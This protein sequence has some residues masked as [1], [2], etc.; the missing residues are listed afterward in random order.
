MTTAILLEDDIALA[1]ELVLGVLEPAEAATAQAR[2]ATDAAFAA[3]VAR[4][5][6]SL[7]P[8]LAGKDVVPPDTVWTKVSSAISSAPVQ[9][10]SK[11]RVRFWQGLSALSTAA[12]LVLAYQVAF[13]P[14]PPAMDIDSSKLIAALGSDTGRAS[15]TASY[16]PIT[17]KL[18]LMP[19]SMDTGQLYPEL[20]IIPEGGT[21]RSLGIVAR[22][23]PSQFTV[24][25]DLGALIDN[26]ATLAITPEPQ[27]GAP[28]GKATGPV[29]ASGTIQSL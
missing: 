21:A 24:A 29:I 9:D 1:G 4:W 7:Q 6:E 2:A 22:D 5:E 26:G 13:A 15:M 12:A 17:G 25:A 16:D 8:M 27:G 19:V 10:N 14:P 23:K 18:T 28:G 3:E 20:W 11:G